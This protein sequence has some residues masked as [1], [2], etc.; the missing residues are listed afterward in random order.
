MARLI[1]ACGA[2]GKETAT[3]NDHPADLWSQLTLPAI[4][5]EPLGKQEKGTRIMAEPSETPTQTQEHRDAKIAK[6]AGNFVLGGAVIMVMIVLVAATLAR[7]GVIDKIAGF[8]PFYM[9]LNPS[10]ALVLIGLLGLG[11]AFWRKTG[12]VAKLAIGTVLSAGMLAAIYT[13]L[14]LPGGNAPPIHDVSTDVD[15]M[16]QFTT[17]DV[18]EVSTGPFSLEEWRAFHEGAY[19]DIGPIIINASPTEV[20]ADAQALAEDRGWEIAAYDAEAGRLEATA[21]A[22][23]VRFYDDV[24]IEVTPVAD[25]STRLDMRSVSRVGVSD[26]GYNAARIRDFLEDMP[27][28]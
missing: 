7:Y 25:G 20:L 10:R 22:G 1:A 26:V 3:A 13:M 2:I 17:L 14:I 12:H 28:G 27:R 6:W 19:G 4:S 9:A 21:T 8:G 24:V 15:D 5:G 11:F 23:Y 18:E 16:P